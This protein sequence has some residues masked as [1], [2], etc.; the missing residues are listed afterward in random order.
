MK[1]YFGIYGFRPSH[2]A[3]SVNGVIPLAESFDTVGI[4]ADDIEIIPDVAEVLLEQP[5]HHSENFTT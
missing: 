5:S 4:K 3:T 1:I 2:N